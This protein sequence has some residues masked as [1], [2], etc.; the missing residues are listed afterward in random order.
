MSAIFRTMSRISTDSKDT[1]VNN[2]EINYPK[3]QNDLDDWKLPKVSNQEIYKK[4][5]FKFFT[6][7]TIRISE[8][9]ISLEQDE[10]VIRLLDSKSIDKHKKD[11]YNF[12]HFGMIQVV[13]KPLTRLGLNTSIVMCLRDNR[14][15]NYRD[16]I[17]GAA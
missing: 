5:T 2:E 4:R 10:E 11:G 7:Y 14:H 8:M 17:I 9:L 1:V 6:N 3:I 15:L 13:A 12:I 16:S